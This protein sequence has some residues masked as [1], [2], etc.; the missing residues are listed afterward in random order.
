[1]TAPFL[2]LM[3]CL[4]SWLIIQTNPL[5]WLKK[6][7]ILIHNAPTH[8]HLISIKP[9]HGQT[10]HRNLWSWGWTDWSVTFQLN[11]WSALYLNNRVLYQDWQHAWF[12][13]S[14]SSPTSK[15]P[16][17]V[18]CQCN[19]GSTNGELMMGFWT[20]LDIVL[21]NNR[22]VIFFLPGRWHQVSCFL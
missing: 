6:C 8:Q 10:N 18:I 19:F 21:R 22:V 20:S 4:N 9:H 7:I 1:M 17:S 11:T 16:C 14:S 15:S 3:V 12:G 5:S 2:E 13:K